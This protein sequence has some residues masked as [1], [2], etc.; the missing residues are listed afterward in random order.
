MRDVGWM[1]EA[2]CSGVVDEMWD[3]S[4]PTPDALRFC[5]RC[6]VRQEC[7]DYGLDRVNASDAGVLGGLGYYDRQKVRAGKATVRDVWRYRITQLAA[8]DWEAA[9]DEQYVRK[10]AR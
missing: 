5:F 1:Q 7:A 6:P 10:M 4:T 9:L 3:L 8:A 2:A